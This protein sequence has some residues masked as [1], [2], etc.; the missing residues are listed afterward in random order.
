MNRILGECDNVFIF[1]EIKERKIFFLSKI[2]DYITICFLSIY[3][4]ILNLAY[5]RDV[6]ADS[7]MSWGLY[8]ALAWAPYFENRF[9][10]LA[11]LEAIVHR[12]RKAYPERKNLLQTQAQRN[13]TLTRRKEDSRIGEKNMSVSN[14]K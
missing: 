1:E 13:I 7:D 6:I 14:K 8:R 2:A 11:T 4:F 10:L 12:I 9:D 3:L 5:V